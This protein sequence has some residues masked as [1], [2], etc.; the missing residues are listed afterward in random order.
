MLVVNTHP[1]NMPGEHWLGVY[2][3]KQGHG[4]FFDSFG[5]PPTH[6][7]FPPDINKFLKQNC[8]DVIYS[9][10]QVQDDDSTACGQHTV[11][12]LYHIQRGLSY[13][14][15]IDKY[16]SNLICNDTMVCRFVNKIQP[17]VCHKY[18]FTCVQCAYVNGCS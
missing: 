2:F 9:T 17:G 11:F 16:G 6:V 5:N 1:S 7:Q 8:T 13:E 3:T 18:D 12:F 4:Y 15:F 14:N 10:K